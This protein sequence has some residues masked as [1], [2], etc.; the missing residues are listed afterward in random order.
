MK[1]ELK[2]LQAVELDILKQVLPII[3]AHGL[4]YYM[5][6]GTLLGAVRHKGFIP[7]DDDIDMGMPR[8]DYER[9]VQLAAQD[10]HAA[11]HLLSCI[12]GAAERRIAIEDGD[13]VCGIRIALRARQAV[14]PVVRVV[15]VRGVVV[16][17]RR[18]MASD[19]HPFVG[20]HRR[21]QD[22]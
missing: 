20:E 3:E 10:L 4:T 18:I 17:P 15:C 13:V 14:R 5:L 11:E 1:Q 7:W 6:G 21:R 8:P 19:P 12:I 16:R 2:Q 9:F 22:G